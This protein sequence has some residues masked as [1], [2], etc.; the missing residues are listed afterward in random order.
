M[1]IPSETGKKI[2]RM[3]RD[4]ALL[5]SSRKKDEKKKSNER[6]YLLLNWIGGRTHPE[7]TNPNTDL[8]LSRIFE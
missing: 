4:V 3:K 8:L 5:A 1:G 6:N 2:G 7:Q